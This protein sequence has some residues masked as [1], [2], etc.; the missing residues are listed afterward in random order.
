MARQPLWGIG[1]WVAVLDDAT[2]ARDHAA[3]MVTDVARGLH[4][5]RAI[6][7][8]QQAFV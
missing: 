5:V 7:R 1:G 3:G 4:I 8:W 6:D 2:A